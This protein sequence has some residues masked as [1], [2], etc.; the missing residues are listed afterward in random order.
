[1]R[2]NPEAS[3]RAYE[4]FKRWAGVPLI[5]GGIATAFSGVSHTLGA[6]L[7]VVGL[8]VIGL[9]PSGVARKLSL[10]GWIIAFLG[11]WA[12][13]V[14]DLL[15]WTESNV[16]QSNPYVVSYGSLVAGLIL[17]TGY[18]LV[19]LSLALGKDHPSPGLALA[20]T[21]FLVITLGDWGAMAV[22]A[23]LIWL[24]LALLLHREQHRVDPGI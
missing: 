24:G 10:I 13:F 8:S 16:L 23:S 20:V 5:L 22:S 15:R 14:M 3:L 21:P 11:A 19:G 1:M 4:F 18:F 9:R 17:L 2:S 7:T 12:V 6:I